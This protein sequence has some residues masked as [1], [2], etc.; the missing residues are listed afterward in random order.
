MLKTSPHLG[1]FFLILIQLFLAINVYT[2]YGWHWDDYSARVIGANNALLANQRLNYAILSEKNVEKLAFD[3]VDR[4]DRSNYLDLE[5]LE[6]YELSQYGPFFELVLIGLEYVL[7]LESH[8]DIFYTRHLA[9]HLFFILA[10]I[11]FY[12]L[13]FQ[14]FKDWKISLLGTLILLLCPRIF[15]HSFFNTKDIPFLSICVLVTFSFFQ[16]SLGD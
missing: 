13:L 4:E 3:K 2:D 10:L 12:F 8:Y 15:A 16:S 9:V 14:Q 1:L 11:F 5:S 6:N 7:G